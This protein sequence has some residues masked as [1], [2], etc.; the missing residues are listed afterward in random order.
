MSRKQE[1][2]RKGGLAKA[3]QATDNSITRLAERLGLTPQAVARWDRV[4]AERC[5]DVEHA[6]GVPRE[7]LRPDIY[8]DRPGRKSQPAGRAA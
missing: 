4:P 1:R 5:L 3:I 6:T 7:I 2:E 8:G